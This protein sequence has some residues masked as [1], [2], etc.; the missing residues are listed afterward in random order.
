MKEMQQELSAKIESEKLSVCSWYSFRHLSEASVSKGETWGLLTLNHA[1]R[2][3]QF[4]FLS[5]Y[6]LLRT[7]QWSSFRRF[8]H[9][10]VYSTLLHIRCL[11]LWHHRSFVRLV[12][13]LLLIKFQICSCVFQNFVLRLLISKRCFLLP[14]ASLI[15]KFYVS[16][17]SCFLTLCIHEFSLLSFVLLIHL[18]L[19]TKR[20]HL[21]LLLLGYILLLNN[22][23]RKICC[24]Q[25]LFLLLCILLLQQWLNSLLLQYGLLGLLKQFE[26]G[27]CYL[28]GFRFFFTHIYYLLLFLTKL[29]FQIFGEITLLENIVKNYDTQ[30]GFP[31]V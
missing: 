3:G 15:F 24:K 23:T 14:L 6:S 19:S 8:S 25:A 18:E 10:S 16:F 17:V 31:T 13:I 4:T 30:R 11:K 29:A 20:Y 27:L 22:L 26:V 5:I 7:R 21:L 12:C 9:Y 28:H 2:S 1:L